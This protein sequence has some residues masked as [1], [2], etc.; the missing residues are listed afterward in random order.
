M[1][2]TKSV[3]TFETRKSV[4]LPDT[5]SLIQSALFAGSPQSRLCAIMLPTGM[6]PAL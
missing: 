1:E 3:V 2:R 4:Y 6:T 5:D